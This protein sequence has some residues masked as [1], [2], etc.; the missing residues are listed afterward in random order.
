MDL[1]TAF[2]IAKISDDLKMRKLESELLCDTIM[3]L[4]DKHNVV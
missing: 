3:Q 4:I 1:Q 2:E